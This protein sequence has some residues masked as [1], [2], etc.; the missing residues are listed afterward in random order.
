MRPFTVAVGDTYALQTILSETTAIIT[1]NDTKSSSNVSFSITCLTD[2]WAPAIDTWCIDS[3]D[4]TSSNYSDTSSVSG[5]SKAFELGGLQLV[6]FGLGEPLWRVGKRFL[7][8]TSAKFSHSVIHCS[9]NHCC[10]QLSSF[11][12][13]RRASAHVSCA[14]EQ[15]LMLTCSTDSNYWYFVYC[16][17]LYHY[18]S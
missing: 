10:A 4:S 7:N 13:H 9:T 12:I 2:N 18:D 3:N 15:L 6:E 1:S 14:L 17:V 16:N 8:L 5:M 11:H